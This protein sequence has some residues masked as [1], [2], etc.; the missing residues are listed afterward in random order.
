MSWRGFDTCGR[1]KGSVVSR[2]AQA[3]VGLT[4]VLAASLPAVPWRVT[5]L[6]LADGLFPHDPA[7]GETLCGTEEGHVQAG[8]RERGTSLAV[9]L[10]QC[11]QGSRVCLLKG[12]VQ[13]LPV[14]ALC[15]PLARSPGYRSNRGDQG[16]SPGWTL[17]VVGA[18]ACGCEA[19]DTARDVHLKYQAICLIEACLAR[20]RGLLEVRPPASP[21]HE[22]GLLCDVSSWNILGGCAVLVSLSPC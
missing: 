5:A 3:T 15:S 20:I 12:L 8:L 14:E 1:L 21:A 22:S 6:H 19:A 2:E 17:L 18:L 16:G 13:G 7:L 9:K 11:P 10:R 4:L